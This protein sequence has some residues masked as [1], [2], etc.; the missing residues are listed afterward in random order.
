MYTKPRKSENTYVP[1]TCRVCTHSI[2]VTNVYDD[3]KKENYGGHRTNFADYTITN[4]SNLRTL[5][6][7]VCLKCNQ[8]RTKNLVLLNME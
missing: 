5:K 8:K 1:D 6:F 3:L 2:N 4:E 7:F